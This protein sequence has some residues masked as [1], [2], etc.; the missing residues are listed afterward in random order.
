MLTA[1]PRELCHL[2]YALTRHQRWDVHVRAWLPALP[3]YLVVVAIMAPLIWAASLRSPW[4]LL[5]SL[6]PL[7]VLRGFVAGFVNIAFVP[8]QRMDVVINELA[9][10]VLAGGERWW[11]FLDSIVRIE[12]FREDL[13]SLVGYHGQAVDIPAALIGPETLAHVRARSEW[14]R[15]PEGVEA[16]VQRGRA[17]LGLTSTAAIPRPDWQGKPDD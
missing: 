8:M 13:W 12:R 7:W 11:I 5:F 17:V 10:G 2:Q 4:Y 9:L 3:R 16:A 1:P 15:T 14:G 6:A